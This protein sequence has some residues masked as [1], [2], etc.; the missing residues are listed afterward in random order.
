MNKELTKKGENEKQER[1][2]INI[3][4][5]VLL[6]LLIQVI[7]SDIIIYF[8][9][10][11]YVIAQMMALLINVI[12]NIVLVKKEIINIKCDFEKWDV[13]FWILLVLVVLLTI[14]FPDEYYDSYSYH[15]YLQ[16]NVFKDKIYEDFFPGRTLTTY[17]YAL[18]DRVYTLFSNKLGFRLGTIPSY[19]VLVVIYYQIK[20][21]LITILKERKIDRKIISIL[22][23]LPICAYIILEQVGTYYIDNI[24]VAILLEFFYITVFESR[25]IFENKKE[26]Y[27]LSLLSG[28]LVSLKFTNA[29]YMVAPL[30]FV[31]IKNFKDIKKIKWYDYIL[32]IIIAFI[33]MFVYMLDAIKDTGSPVFPYYNSIFK[34]RY[35]KEYDWFD[36]AYG[37]NGILEVLFWPI[38]LKF[39][40][41]RGYVIHE[42]DYNYLFGYLIS[43][44][45]ISYL[46]I[47]KMMR[48]IRKEKS[49]FI[50]DKNN[51]IMSLII[52]Y[53]NFVLAKFCIGYVR[54]GSF[55]PILSGI[56]IIK[57]IVDSL[58]KK[59]LFRTVFLSYAI[60]AAA[61]LGISNYFDTGK[62]TYYKGL[63][64]NTQSV[65]ERVAINA[66]CVFKDQDYLKYDIDG[67]WGVIG[68]DSAVPS[69]LN[70]DDKIVQ[71]RCGTMTGDTEESN[72][73]YWDNVLKNDIYVPMFEMKKDLK[74]QQLDEY[75]FEI[76]EVVDYIP[77]VLYMLDARPIY[78]IKVKYNPD[79]KESNNQ[80]YNRL[81]ERF[82]TNMSEK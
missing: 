15:I 26:L 61:I 33:P 28:I 29:F 75:K 59:Q 42:I 45:Y 44:S 82:I 34:S 73:I 65:L 70:V 38:V 54:Y 43:L 39:F 22:S 50:Y 5:Y 76:V 1:L 17:T 49:E 78:I 12:F 6:L 57:L 2:M 72:R 14:I 18:A 60:C 53:S 31:L 80:I 36:G 77:N 13:V 81:M 52:L 71:L 25:S 66:A 20:K 24:C 69:M 30:I 46:I 35:F 56:F 23:I 51:L 8:C 27:Y 19:F 58:E 55:I 32:L 47:R 68:D 41:T 10:F 37:T 40:P 79:K 3:S 74:L 9:G 7:F 67:I 64:S 11:K 48:Y 21:Y 63:F 62:M 16:K 4:F